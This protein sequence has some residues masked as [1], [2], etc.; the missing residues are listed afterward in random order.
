MLAYL[1]L[2]S[3][4]A[5]FPALK[6]PKPASQKSNKWD[7]RSRKNSRDNRRK[8]FAPQ[9][10]GQQQGVHCKGAHGNQ[11]KPLYRPTQIP[12]RPKR[13]SI[14]AYERDPKRCQEGKRIGDKWGGCCGYQQQPDNHNVDSCRNHANDTKTSCDHHFMPKLFARSAFFNYDFPPWIVLQSVHGF[15]AR[16]K[17]VKPAKRLRARNGSS[18]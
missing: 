1:T 18:A 9:K 15:S 11:Q 2:L 10:D 14:I 17:A 13:P 5:L 7:D 12:W 6:S 16:Q 3:S 4:R 8:P